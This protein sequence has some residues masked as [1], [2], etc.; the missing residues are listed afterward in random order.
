MSWVQ[1][2]Y[3]TYEACAGKPQFSAQPLLPVSHTEQQ[4]HIEVVLD[5]H[6]NFL[7]AQ[8]LA[9]EVT[10]IPVTEESAGRTRKAVPHPLCDKIQYCAG[11]YVQFGGEKDSGFEEF[12]RQLDDWCQTAK[13]PKLN[14]VLAY[15][16]KRCLV[17][18]LIQ[19]AIM[20]TGP[21][22]KLI[23]TWTSEGSVP[24]LF[25]QL[26]PDQKTKKRDQGS[27]FVRW[28]VE[29]PGDPN[30]AVWEDKAIQDSWTAFDTARDSGAGFCISTGQLAPLAVNHPKR[31]RHGGDGAKLISTN[32]VNG[33]TFRGRFLDSSQAYGLSA[34]VTQKVHNALRW[35]IDRQAYRNGD[36]SIV[37][38]SVEGKLIPDPF[39]DTGTLFG[40]DNEVPTQVSLDPGD[41]GQHYA[42]RLGRAMAGFRADLSD[43]D[44]IVV[45]GLDSATPGRMAI[46]FYRELTGSEFLE[47]IGKWHSQ[48]AWHQRLSKDKTFVGAPAPR[49]IAQ[50]IFGTRSNADEKL[51][52]AT[53]E[54]LLP[55]IV[56]GGRV[57]RDLVLSSVR[58]A[59]N[60][61]GQEW[62]EWERC[63][64][65]ACSLYRGSNAERGYALS[66][67]LDRN[68]RDYLFGRLLAIAENL[69]EKALYLAHEKRE[70]SAGKL[71]QR[72]ASRP[73]ST[74]RN[75]ELALRPYIS[76][77]R[78]NRPSVLLEREKLLDSVMELFQSGEF[79]TDAP[80]SG[81]FL[82]GYHCQRAALWGR[83]SSAP[84][85]SATEPKN[86][87]VFA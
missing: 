71:M 82:L 76:R 11:D 31:L 8:V 59:S 18:D 28:R 21:D 10:L 60:R 43:S 66:L 49:E 69:E 16:S 26:A 68:S 84:E 46:S 34:T 6:G 79:V 48:F 23:T 86:E 55:C 12:L 72:F 75:I 58:K 70:T 13:L 1:K 27:A 54:R 9:K 67:E 85:S 80:L 17:S 73:Y 36:A 35:L 63:L 83:N 47:R 53:V 56:D 57:P 15:V 19:A 3:E 61:A 78:S 40:V 42:L 14:A 32:D 64:G 25:K 2:L 24:D 37:A 77:L 29:I 50:S 52:R 62:W 20:Q 33:Y 87:G 65:V 38:W 39:Q 5:G 7:R 41:V 4:A 74:W 51:V 81:E 30:S 22:G 45:M 44:A